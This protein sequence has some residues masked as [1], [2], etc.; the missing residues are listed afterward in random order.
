MKNTASLWI[1]AIAILGSLGFSQKADAR[2]A[3]C[4]G[5]TADSQF[6]SAA[7]QA[8]GSGYTQ[9]IT[10]LVVNPETG[11]SEYVTLARIAPGGHVNVISANNG[12]KSL[13]KSDDRKRN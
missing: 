3:L 1:F 2:V 5:C 13:K 11:L 9:G 6:Q 12:L 4:V 10:Y 7:W 8:F